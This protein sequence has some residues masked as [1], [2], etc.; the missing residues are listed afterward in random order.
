MSKPKLF[1]HIGLGKTGTTSLQNFFARNRKELYSAGVIYPEYGAVSNAHHLLS[2]HQPPFLKSLWTFI[3][4]QEWAPKLARDADRPVLLSSEIISSLD[5]ALVPRFAAAIR[6]HFDVR[7][8]VYLRRIDNLVMATYNQQIKAGTQRT[9]IEDSAFI[10]F[11]RLR[12]DKKLQPWIDAFGGENIDVRAYERRQFRDGDICGDFLE[13]TFGIKDTGLFTAERESANSNPRLSYAALEFKRIINNVIPNTQISSRFNSALLDYSA[14]HDA[15]STSVFHEANLLPNAVRY[16]M[17]K[18]QDA[19]LKGIATDMMKRPDGRVFHDKAPDPAQEW[20][21]PS[22]THEEFSAI[23][24]SLKDRGLDKLLQS[25]IEEA[26]AASDY[27]RYLH[28]I[29]LMPYL[30]MT[31]GALPASKP[32]GAEGRLRRASV[33]GVFKSLWRS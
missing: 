24:R 28:A 9:H 25:Q 14:R 5:A 26:Y 33:A 19:T 31:C 2:P 4:A 29:K 27:L 22:Y 23:A 1:L 10:L 13:R 17:L 21:A 6:P 18:Q 8:I 3:D 16:L 11:E 32:E 15:E 20:T 7:V 30:G 12:F